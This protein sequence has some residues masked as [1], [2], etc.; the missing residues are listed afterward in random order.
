MKPYYQDEWNTIYFGDCLS[1]L[2][3][4]GPDQVDVIMTDPV[5]PNALPELKGSA[6]PYG[7]FAQTANY[8]PSIADRLIVILGCD[9]DPRFLLA[10]P[11]V[12]KFQ[13]VTWLRR[14]PPGYKGTLLYNA[15][16][17]YV[18]GPGYLVDNGKRLLPGE[19]LSGV[20]TG[21][22][23]WWCQHPAYRSPKQ[24]EWLINNYT[25]TDHTILDPFMGVGGTVIAARVH[26]RK[27]IG[28]EIEEKYCEITA[29]RCEQMVME[30][31]IE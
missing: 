19:Y 1:I 22:K 20:S 31:K 24:M 23:E 2:P 25:R 13:R 27:S 5:W 4:I 3:D 10:V 6:D 16:L 30:L 14:T 15:D 17:A 11:A 21:K 7:L 8:F 18:F 9:S 28:I 29:K 26:G 12:M